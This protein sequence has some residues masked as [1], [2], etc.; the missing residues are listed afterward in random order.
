VSISEKKFRE[1]SLEKMST[2][3]HEGREFRDFRKED[4]RKD[5]RK[6]DF[7]K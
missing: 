5:F 1:S 7:R 4:F 3:L 6:E 2:C